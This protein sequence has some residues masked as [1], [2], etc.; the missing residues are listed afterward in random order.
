M[1]LKILNLNFVVQI[2]YLTKQSL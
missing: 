2:L 1:F